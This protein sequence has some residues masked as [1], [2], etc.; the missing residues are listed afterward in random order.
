MKEDYDLAWKRFVALNPQSRLELCPRSLTDL[1]TQFRCLVAQNALGGLISF[2]HLICDWEL[3]FNVNGC[4]LD[5]SKLRVSE[6]QLLEFYALPAGWSVVD[7]IFLVAA[8]VDKF[9]KTG[10]IG[11]DHASWALIK[12]TFDSYLYVYSVCATM[13]NSACN[14]V[15]REVSSLFERFKLLKNLRFVKFCYSQWKSTYQSLVFVTMLQ[16]QASSFPLPATTTAANPQPT[17]NNC[18][19]AAA[20]VGIGMPSRLNNASPSAVT[21]GGMSLSPANVAQ[22]DPAKQASLV[23]R[24]RSQQNSLLHLLEE[25]VKVEDK[26]KKKARR[27]ASG[28]KRN[29]EAKGRKEGEKGNKEK[30]MKEEEKLGKE[31]RNRWKEEDETSLW[32]GIAEHG[33]SWS[34]IS[35]VY[36]PG[37]THHQVKDKGKRLLRGEGWITGRSRESSIQACDR[38][39]QIALRVLGKQGLLPANVEQIQRSTQQ[40]RPGLQ[41]PLPQTQTTPSTSR[42]Y[43]VVAPMRMLNGAGNG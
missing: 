43:P 8:V 31:K 40:G 25:A 33:N 39:K 28:G 20:K 37:R 38:A 11:E 17:T 21:M 1:K 41:P 4:L 26:P 18:N 13:A 16:L 30:E 22:N 5:F 34:A 36:L 7:D 29:G 24:R 23:K 9:L 6:Q 27:Q 2:A 15:P 35:Q 10:E 42:V 19:V 32:K 14:F 3:K 12:S